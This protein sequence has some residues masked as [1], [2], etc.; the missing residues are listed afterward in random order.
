VLKRDAIKDQLSKLKAECDMEVKQLQREKKELIETNKEK[1]KLEELKDVIQRTK[2]G[3]RFPRAPEKGNYLIIIVIIMY[4]LTLI[5]KVVYDDVVIS[6]LVC[7]NELHGSLI[8]HQ[9]IRFSI[10]LPSRL[11]VHLFHW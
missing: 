6:H 4:V 1:A 5:I 7:F 3:L 9:P 10:K 2:S 11:R 8:W